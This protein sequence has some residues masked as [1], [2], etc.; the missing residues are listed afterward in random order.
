MTGLTVEPEKSFTVRRLAVPVP[1]V[2][3]SRTPCGSRPEPKSPGGYESSV[4]L[5]QRLIPVTQ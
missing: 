4:R 1:G 3:A 2:G 5:L